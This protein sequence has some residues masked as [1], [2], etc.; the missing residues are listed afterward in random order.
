MV[1]PASPLAQ[2][3]GDRSWPRKRLGCQPDR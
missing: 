3:S 1:G 2:L